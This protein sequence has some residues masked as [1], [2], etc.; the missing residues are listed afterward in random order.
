MIIL[1]FT[2]CLICYGVRALPVNPYLVH[3]EERGGYFDPLL[4]YL[5]GSSGV[6]S[7][8]SGNGSIVDIPLTR[9]SLSSE[10]GVTTLMGQYLYAINVTLGT[11]G[12]DFS[13]V[14]DTGSSNF[15]V[16]SDSCQSLFCLDKTKYVRGNSSIYPDSS[17]SKTMSYGTGSYNGVV[18]Y[19]KMI[20]GPFT[21]NSQKFTRIL[22]VTSDI[23]NYPSILFY[24][25]DKKHFFFFSLFLRFYSFFYPAQNIYRHY[26]SIRVL[27]ESWDFRSATKLP[28][29]TI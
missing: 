22:N 21:V 29:Y 24:F 17:E 25:R 5:S 23:V 6:S 18:G 12:Q 27:T 4:Q 20:I 1:Y 28:A 8:I 7:S 11:P 15:W 9:I 16:V 26:N 19:D 2:L 13:V 3:L 10:L 14:V